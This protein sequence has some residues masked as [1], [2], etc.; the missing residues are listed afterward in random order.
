MTSS[1]KKEQ[2]PK[3]EKKPAAEKTKPAASSSSG[4]QALIVG[5]ILLALVVVIA[6]LGWQR[7][8]ELQNK[9]AEQANAINS[10]KSAITSQSSAMEQS[11]KADQEFA[12]AIDGLKQELGNDKAG[13]AHNEAAY[14][15]H[16]A[17]Y[18]L[19]FQQDVK[20]AITLLNEADRIINKA[21]GS[22]SIKL[23]EAL[24]NDI[25]ALKNID[26]PD[27]AGMTLSLTGL[28]TNVNV[29]TLKK[30][31]KE[32]IQADNNVA[33]DNVTDWQQFVF[34][35]WDNIRQLVVIRRTET[36]AAPLL[37]P[38]EQYFLFQNL[39]LKLESTRL[40]LLKG[41]TN[42]F[43]ANIDAAVAWLTQ[44][45]DAD[46]TAVKSTIETLTAMKQVNLSPTLPE[47]ASLSVVANTRGA[48]K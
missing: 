26:L 36:G 29:L 6:G 35:L 46:A 47:L 9:V 22:E 30:Q 19:R 34:A 18:R 4:N 11:R 37:A 32:K 3:H 2:D 8:H 48:V 45:F 41:D 15:I 21:G 25:T 27:A 44:Y 40:S 5:I 39:Q 23:R 14:L 10:L 1:S 16:L 33:G 28:T 20:T 43:H 7:Y 38:Q 17:N 42:S 13:R 24:S 12:D 31:V